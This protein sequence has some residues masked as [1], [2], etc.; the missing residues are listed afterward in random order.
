MR[1]FG[2]RRRF[3]QYDFHLFTMVAWL[4]SDLHLPPLWFLCWFQA[5][6]F[7]DVVETQLDDVDGVGVGVDSVGVQD[8]ETLQS[9]DPVFGQN[10]F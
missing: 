4:A 10:P 2:L 9:C 7:Q 3:G 5:D 1:R 8:A 6:L